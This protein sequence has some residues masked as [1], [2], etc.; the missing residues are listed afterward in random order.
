MLQRTMQH[1][2]QQLNKS[3]DQTLQMTLQQLGVAEDDVGTSAPAPDLRGPHAVA[4]EPLHGPADNLRASDAMRVPSGKDMAFGLSDNEG[5]FDISDIWAMESQ[6]S[7]SQPSRVSQSESY[8]DV[9]RG[10]YRGA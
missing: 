6:P 9:Y 1:S 7:N 3:S 10:G 5:P 4:Q 2:L 8:S